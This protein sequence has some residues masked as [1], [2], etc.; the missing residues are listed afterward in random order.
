MYTQTSFWLFGFF[1]V[2]EI[3]VDAIWILW[4]QFD[5]FL[6]FLLYPPCYDGWPPNFDLIGESKTKVSARARATREEKKAGVLS[7]WLITT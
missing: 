4:S 3:V 1:F 2:F 5:G 6:Y 7:F